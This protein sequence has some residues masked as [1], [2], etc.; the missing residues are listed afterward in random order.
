MTLNHPINLYSRTTLKQTTGE[1]KEAYVF[2]QLVWAYANTRAGRE[3]YM[4]GK[5][6]ATG[7]VIFTVYWDT[8]YDERQVI[9]WDD[10]YYDIVHIAP[11][12]QQE[13]LEITAEWREE[14]IETVYNV[15]DASGDLLVDE[16]GNKIILW[17]L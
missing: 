8:I 16:E 6:T 7:T 13:Y 4:A 10:K 14:T 9:E 15:T 17:E 3:A 5:T 2:E 1:E 12:G 11:R